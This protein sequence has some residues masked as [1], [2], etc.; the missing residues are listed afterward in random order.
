MAKSK[1]LEYDRFRSRVHNLDIAYSVE[2]VMAGNEAIVRAN[3]LLNNIDDIE[4]FSYEDQTTNLTDILEAYMILVEYPSMVSDEIYAADTEFMALLS[5]GYVEALSNIRMEDITVDNTFGLTETK[6]TISGLIVSEKKDKLTLNDFVG[7]KSGINVISSEYVE[8]F[9]EIFEE[10]YRRSISKKTLEEWLKEF[11]YKG[12]FEHTMYQPTLQF[13]S[14][15]M[16]ITFLGVKQ[17]MDAIA[18]G[19]IITGESYTHSQ[20]KWKAVEAVVSMG[21]SGKILSKIIETSIKE[22]L[23]ELAISKIPDAIV[24]YNET[25]F[26]RDS[27]IVKIANMVITIGS[28]IK[29]NKIV[30]F[31]KLFTGEYKYVDDIVDVVDDIDEVVDDLPES[32][33]DAYDS[34]YE[35]QRQINID[36]EE[37]L[38][39]IRELLR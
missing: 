36:Y 11:V 25:V 38:E 3:E 16:D 35:I 23:V 13:L 10:Q 8:G 15:F 22:V 6:L 1:R 12:E 37:Y 30:D 21:I 19:D 5:K 17:A 20:R 24:L 29:I 18:G 2:T 33:E 27:K 26:D 28:N 32:I 14:G 9:A 39:N 34:I 7:R 4:G 31:V